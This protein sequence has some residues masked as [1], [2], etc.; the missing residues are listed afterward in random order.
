MTYKCPCDRCIL[1]AMCK[2]KHIDQLM[3]SCELVVDYTEFIIV[4]DEVAYNNSEFYESDHY[5]FDRL[6]EVFKTL[7]P[8]KWSLNDMFSGR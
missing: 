6:I 2:H 4:P 5:N 7:T 3:I 8:T 1:V